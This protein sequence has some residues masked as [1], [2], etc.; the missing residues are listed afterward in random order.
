MVSTFSFQ[1]L[2]GMAHLNDVEEA[3]ENFSL[4]P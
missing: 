1:K 3:G 2:K 4:K